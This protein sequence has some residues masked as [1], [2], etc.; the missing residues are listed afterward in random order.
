M[1]LWW[2][3][4]SFIFS[5]YIRVQWRMPTSIAKPSKFASHIYV[6]CIDF[7][8]HSICLALCQT[9]YAAIYHVYKSSYWFRQLCV[10]SGNNGRY[11]SSCQCN[12]FKFFLFNQTKFYKLTQ[13]NL[14]IAKCKKNFPKAQKWNV[15][16]DFI[17]ESL[18][19]FQGFNY[20]YRFCCVSINNDR[21]SIASRQKFYVHQ[22]R[23][24]GL[25]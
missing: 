18:Q 1:G 14:P 19:H 25:C 7:E 5:A 6:Q 17:T 13:H 12:D 15:L 11:S 22:R 8:S 21:N 23:V 20:G 10:T 24:W 4:Y 3:F 2:C 9:I 16:I